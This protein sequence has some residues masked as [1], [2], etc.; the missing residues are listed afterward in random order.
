MPGNSRWWWQICTKAAKTVFFAGA[1]I[2]L[3]GLNSLYWQQCLVHARKERSKPLSRFPWML[4]QVALQTKVDL[5]PWCLGTAQGR[6]AAVLAMCLLWKGALE[7][8]SIRD[9]KEGP[10]VRGAPLLW[11]GVLPLMRGWK[12]LCWPDSCSA[13][14]TQ[15]FC[16]GLLWCNISS[17][18]ER[19]LKRFLSLQVFGFYVVYCSQQWQCFFQHS[20]LFTR[21]WQR[22][23][24]GKDAKS[25]MDKKELREA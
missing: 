1:S 16:L 20:N 7:Q 24:F 15:C 8:G 4:F 10:W 12:Q 9:K 13:W 17:F 25:V 22:T 18:P 23:H 19:S 11:Q 2:M 21:S 3:I 14:L 5:L 6:N